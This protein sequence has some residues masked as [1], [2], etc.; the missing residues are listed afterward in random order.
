MIDVLHLG[1]SYR[2]NM[3]CKHCFVDKK[4]DM[5]NYELICHV[6]DYLYSNGLLILYYTYGEPLLSELFIPVSLYVAKKGIVQILMTNG[7]QINS[8]TCKQFINSG[9]NTVYVSIDHSDSN[10]HDANRGYVGAFKK[11]ISALRICKES[12][13][14]TGISCTVTEKNVGCLDGIRQIALHEG[15]GAVSFLRERQK[16]DVAPFSRTS[17]ELYNS[18]FIR[19]LESDETPNWKFH[20]PTLIPILNT[21]YRAG[22][23]SE[24]V[25]R[26]YLEMNRCHANNTLSIAPDGKVYGCNLVGCY[27]GDLSDTP[28]ETILAKES[29]NECSIC[30][31]AISKSR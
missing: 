6:I 9:I 18:F 11:A 4:N 19:C 23:I 26:K 28:I 29:K 22:N 1:L 3:R 21:E 8:T 7:S 5:L 17:Q 31:S 15:V 27:Q 12:G 13:V 30:R 16:G 24:F 20:D 14:H 10:A 2:C 25:F